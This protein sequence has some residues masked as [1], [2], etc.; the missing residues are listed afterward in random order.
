MLLLRKDWLVVPLHNVSDMKWLNHDN[1][2]VWPNQQLNL[3][4]IVL[5]NETHSPGLVRSVKRTAHTHTHIVSYT[6]LLSCSDEQ[7]SMSLFSRSNTPYTLPSSP[8]VLARV[9]KVCRVQFPGRA[10]LCSSW[11]ANL[12]DS[13]L[14]CFGLVSLV[15]KAT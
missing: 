4:S 15:T 10:L 2:P 5:E 8:V 14:V 7:M 11:G 9:E 6:R 1:Y 12:L 13:V 3:K